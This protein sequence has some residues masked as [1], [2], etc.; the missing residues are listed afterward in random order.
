MYLMLLNDMTLALH[1]YILA[2]NINDSLTNVSKTEQ[3]L[4]MQYKYETE[5]REAEITFLNKAQ[6][7][8]K[9]NIEKLIVAL[10]ATIALVMVMLL[11]YRRVQVQKAKLNA[12]SQKLELMMKELHHRVKNN[13]Q[14]VTSLLSLQSYKSSDNQVISSFKRKPAKGA[15][16]EPYT[17][18]LV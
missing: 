10:L 16:N 9:G 14:I 15:G 12:Q 11:L 2:T 17:P 7:T 5:K 8:N 4:E 18:A 6:V 3:V 13:L 1:Y